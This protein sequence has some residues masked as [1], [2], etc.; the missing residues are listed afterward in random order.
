MVSIVQKNELGPER[1]SDS[2]KVRWMVIRA[3]IRTQ[4]L[5]L[6]YHGIQ[7]LPRTDKGSH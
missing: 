2:S 3:R 6:N 7:I 4:R 5:A 1:L